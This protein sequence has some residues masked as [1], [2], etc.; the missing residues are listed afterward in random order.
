MKRINESFLSNIFFN[1]LETIPLKKPILVKIL[2][3]EILSQKTVKIYFERE[4][5]EVFFI[6]LHTRNNFTVDGSL[7]PF[8][9][10]K[11]VNKLFSCS[12]Y[13]NLNGFLSLE[14]AIYL[15]SAKK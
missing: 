14:K 6:L 13:R 4:T 7:I 10:K 11:I 2:K 9:S 15:K 3:R 1:K 8:S 5:E 12:F